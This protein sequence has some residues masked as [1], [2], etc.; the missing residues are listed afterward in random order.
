MRRNQ[1]L[2][3]V[4]GLL[5]LTAI[6]GLF[7]SKGTYSISERLYW[8]DRAHYFEPIVIEEFSAANLP[9]FTVQVGDKPFLAEFDLGFR[10]CISL[11][12]DL[13]SGI[14]PKEFLSSRVNYG[15]RGTGYTIDMYRIPKMKIGQRIFYDPILQ[16]RSEALDRDSVVRSKKTEQIEPRK[17]GTI[18]WEI[19]QPVNLWI[20]LGNSS[21]AFCDSLESLKR[22]GYPVETFAKSPLLLDRFLIEFEAMT[23]DGFLRCVLDTGATWNLLHTD[24]KEGET[25]EQMIE[26]DL[27]EIRDFQVNGVNL[28]KMAFH[29]IP[30]KLPIQIDAVLGMEFFSN[31]CVFIDFANAMI[32]ISPHMRDSGQQPESLTVS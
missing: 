13:L 1:K 29:P 8:R 31:H 18:G 26:N 20:G 12:S 5:A 21:I 30:I 32:Y 19:F 17:T 15:F 9:F 23:T 16:G 28:K 6:W 2:I 4:G 22:K 14:E 25:L 7:F 3:A 27:V 24:M 11:P 10:G